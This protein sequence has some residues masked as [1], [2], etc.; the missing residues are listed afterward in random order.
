MRILDINNLPSNV[1]ID[2]TNPIQFAPVIIAIALVV[3]VIS[4]FY[5]FNKKKLNHK[6]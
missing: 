4:V 3:V 2:N 6:E 1:T 5:F